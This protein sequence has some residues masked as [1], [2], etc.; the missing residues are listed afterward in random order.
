MSTWAGVGWRD[1]E[2]LKSSQWI[3]HIIF[4]WNALPYFKIDIYTAAKSCMTSD[5]SLHDLKYIDITSIKFELYYF[6]WLWLTWG[7]NDGLV[8]RHFS[9]IKHQ[10][11][12]IR[13][14][15]KIAS[16]IMTC[17]LKWTLFRS[18]N[19][20]ITVILIWKS[21]KKIILEQIVNAKH[22]RKYVDLRMPDYC[23]NKA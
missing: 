10:V 9:V 17:M 12:H 21:H 11:R 2:W 4:A 20:V 13:A 16:I 6:E 14:P 19:L 15:T 18:R 5:F 7:I 8:F 1:E 22:L 23:M 3:S